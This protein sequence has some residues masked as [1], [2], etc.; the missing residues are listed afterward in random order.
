MIFLI[1]DTILCFLM[2]LNTCQFHSLNWQGVHPVWAIFISFVYRGLLVWAFLESHMI[3]LI[4]YF[5]SSLSVVLDQTQMH[6]S[7]I[8]PLDCFRISN[9]I[10][11]HSV[12]QP[13]LQEVGWKIIEGCMFSSCHICVSEWIHTL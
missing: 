6:H 11:I 4:Y 13:Y 10:Y 2:L 5:K 3:N 9:V 1:F 8:S 7:S 12:N